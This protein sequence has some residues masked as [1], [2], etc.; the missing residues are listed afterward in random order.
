MS[1]RKSA[2]VLRKRQR[3]ETQAA[4]NARRGRERLHLDLAAAL[5]CDHVRQ[6]FADLASSRIASWIGDIGP[7]GHEVVFLNGDD[8]PRALLRI[9]F[10]AN[11]GPLGDRLD[12]LAT[13]RQQI[14]AAAKR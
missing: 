8:P 11:G 7:H 2:P 12:D 3:L 1:S 10:T 4:T 6:A 14:I 9:T 5:A 13:P